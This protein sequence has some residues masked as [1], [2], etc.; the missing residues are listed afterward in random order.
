MSDQKGQKSSEIVT[1]R[2]ENISIDAPNKGNSSVTK[3]GKKSSSKIDKKLSKKSS[4]SKKNGK[5]KDKES[6]GKKSGSQKGL[7]I[8]WFDE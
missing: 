7:P 4:S 6:K 8:D 3:D 5:I 1:S 2:V